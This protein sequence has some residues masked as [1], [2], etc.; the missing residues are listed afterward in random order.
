MANLLQKLMD[1]HAVFNLIE[2]RRSIALFAGF[3]HTH[4]AEIVVFWKIRLLISHFS[5]NLASK[6]PIFS[7]KLKNSSAKDKKS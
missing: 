3:R 5:M 6:T 2:N 4:T 7:K 1:F